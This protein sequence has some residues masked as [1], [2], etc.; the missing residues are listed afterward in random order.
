MGD[1]IWGTAR[2]AQKAASEF[3]WGGAFIENFFSSFLPGP[4]IQIKDGKLLQL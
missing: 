3:V 2:V 1:V 4:F